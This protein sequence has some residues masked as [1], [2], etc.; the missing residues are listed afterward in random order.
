MTETKI[1]THGA[2]KGKSVGDDVW[3]AHKLPVTGWIKDMLNRSISDAIIYGTVS[4]YSPQEQ[5]TTIYVGG[6][7]E[8][9]VWLNGT[10]DLPAESVIREMTITLIF[11]Q[12]HF[13]R[14]EMSY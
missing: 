2:V 10:S 8:I 3:T 1:A 14:G 9:K 7:R 12:S 13:S 5:E 6:H 4:L 11:T